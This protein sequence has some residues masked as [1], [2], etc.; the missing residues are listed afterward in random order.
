MSDR[1][2]GRSHSPPSP[3]QHYFSVD[4][5]EWF[6]V[7]AFEHLVT[8]ADWSRLESRVVRFTE[9][10]LEVLEEHGASGTF[11]VLGSVAE[12]YPDLVRSI[13]AAGH[14]VA[15]HGFGHQ[16][17][18]ALGAAAF[19]EDVRRA[20]SVIEQAL[21][22]PIV[23]FRAPSFSLL[24]SVPWAAA[25]LVEEGH[26]YDSSRFPIRR[27]GYGVPTAP[28]VP[29]WLDTP[30]GPLLEIP[31]AV[32]ERGG[33]RFPIA[34]GGWFRQL[35]SFVTRAGFR[36]LGREGRSGVFYLHPWE[37]DPGQ[38]RIDAPLLTRMRHYRGL[39]STQKRLVQLLK[40]FRFHALRELLTTADEAGLP[41]LRFG[42]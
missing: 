1:F 11:F 10:L 18:P 39:P 23:G 14:E 7:N 41:R 8:R 6:Q 9:L 36:A 30:S 20:K 38:P 19:R 31:P 12:R 16:R 37:L 2:S 40:E 35:P 15:S 26:L 24:D 32:W 28:V 25:I 42:E 3:V 22:E 27:K 29:H 4:V 17:L 33:I 21:G 5:E 34:G 13:A